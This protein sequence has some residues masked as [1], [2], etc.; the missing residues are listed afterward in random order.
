MRRSL[1]GSR[2]VTRVASLFSILLL[3]STDA[4]GKSKLPPCPND[5]PVSSWNNCNGTTT[6]PNGSE[7]VGE[8]KNGKASGQGAAM[9]ANGRTY[10]GEFR[11]DKFNGQGTY[12]ETDGSIMSSGK[13]VDDKFAG[14]VGNQE[15]IRMEKNGGVYVVPVRFN[16]AITLDAVVD[17]GASD[18]SIPADVVLTLMRTKTVSAQDFLGQ[19]TYVLADGSK[20]P[21]ERFRIRSMKVGNKT[22]ENVTASITPVKGE[23]L[24]GQSFLSKFKS[25]SIDNET[26]VLFLRQGNEASLES[27][28][29]EVRVKGQPKVIPQSKQ[30]P[31][32]SPQDSPAPI[33]SYSVQVSSQ[34]SLADAQV[35]YQY[36]QKVFP[37]ILG[38]RQAFIHKVDLGEHGIL[39]RAE[40]GQF[41]TVEEASDLCSRL[42][43]A[44]GQ[45]IVQRN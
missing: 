3:F 21:S 22:V 37:S 38:G 12:F 11:N 30:P 42:K 19:Q 25:W 13:W 9:F 43:A 20:V 8:F 45:C 35:A 24:L 1:P 29:P 15:T 26:H 39:Y 27:Q 31:S 41:R 28:E 14:T 34:R 6:F 16:D 2:A 5:E 18:V 10:V 32:L 7:Y 36:M 33:G 4:I 44:G 23:I 17:S 40:V